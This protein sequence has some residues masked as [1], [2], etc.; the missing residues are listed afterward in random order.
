[1]VFR[2]L[3]LN[4]KCAG[5][6]IKPVLR[7]HSFSYRWAGL[8]SQVLNDGV[9]PK[10]YIMKYKEWFLEH[11]EPGWVV[12]DIGSNTGMLPLM[13]AEKAAFVYGIEL[14]EKHVAVAK[15]QHAKPNIEY[16]CADATTHNYDS[17]QPV[18]CVTLSNVLE[19]IEHRVDFLKRI[20]RQVKWIDAS[21][22]RLLFRVPMIN[23]EWIVLYKKELGL[24]YRLDPTHHIE[25]T[26]EQFEEELGQAG[27]VPKKVEIRFGEIYA[28]CEAIS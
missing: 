10:H 16:I 14:S 13:L 5:I 12:M 24:D 20:V 3:F 17:Y 7:L 23:R 26:L 27:I 28:M 2:K 6:L 8:F 9:H 19:H 18:N 25:Y 11:I 22:R 4:K 1:M 15:T 21:H